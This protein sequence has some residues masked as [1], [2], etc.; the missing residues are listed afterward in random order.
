MDGCSLDILEIKILL[1]KILTAVTWLNILGF[2]AFVFFLIRLCA[3]R[4][5]K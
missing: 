2:S 5:R 4:K 1:E 3:I